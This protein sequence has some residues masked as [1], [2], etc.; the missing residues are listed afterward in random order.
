M[1]CELYPILNPKILYVSN[2]CLRTSY[3][4]EDVLG[5]GEGGILKKTFLSR[6]KKHLRILF[7]FKNSQVGFEIEIV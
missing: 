6:K 4:R 1:T 7:Y 2:S 5:V 3:A